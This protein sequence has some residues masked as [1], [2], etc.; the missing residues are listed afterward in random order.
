MAGSKPAG[1][2]ARKL[3]R[4]RMATAQQARR[5]REEANTT[6]LEQ[7]FRADERIDT[8]ATKRD[9]A[10]AA[11]H[12]TYAAVETDE[13]DTQAAALRRIRYRGTTRSELVELTG[14]T[15][16]Q[17]GKL[18]KR[19]PD[20]ASASSG[21]TVTPKRAE[22]GTNTSASTT[23]SVETEHVLDA[24]DASTAHASAEPS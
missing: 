21:A 6:D 12:T 1:V 14:L 15:S 19:Q 9:T 10:I 3:A 23:H 22:S 20:S 24:T 16:G 7:I 18:L 2:T 17:I 8:A 13:L 5:E 4:E 11:A